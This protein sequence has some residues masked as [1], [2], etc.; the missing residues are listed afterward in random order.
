MRRI[1][2][3]DS[4]KSEGIWGEEVP[5]LL[6]APTREYRTATMDSHLWDNF[7]PRADDIVVGTYTKCGTT[8]TQQIV[9]LLIFQDPDPRPVIQIAPWLD[10][11]LTPIEWSLA[12]LEA[13][14]HRRS[15]KTH[16]PFDAVPIYEGVKYIH[17]GRDGLDASMSLHNHLFNFRPEIKARRAELASADPRLRPD[18][19]TPSDPRQYFLNWI[20]SAEEYS[21]DGYGVDLPFFEFENTYWRERRR[22]NVLFVHYNDLKA[23]LEAE[24]RRIADFLEL[25]VSQSVWPSLVKAATF[26]DMKKNGAS[27]MPGADSTWDKG[28]DRFFNEGTNERWKA[29][30]KA[31]DVARYHALVRKKWSKATAAWVTSGRRVAGDPRLSED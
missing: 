9:Q 21:G 28:A 10:R 24:M 3:L 25:E 19:D 18:A 13:Q 1:R 12:T 7:K 26:D 15:V 29:I 6:R 11:V 5:K 8:W 30:L 22:P 16:M 27:L 14:T 23:D 2:R 17:V 31:D 20:G 4:I